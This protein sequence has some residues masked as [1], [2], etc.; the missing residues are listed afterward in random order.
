MTTPNDSR[1]SQLADQWEK[2]GKTLSPSG[3]YERTL[4]AC[5]AELRFVIAGNPPASTPDKI[6]LAMEAD[7]P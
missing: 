3:E 6:R 1:L 5:A 4:R 7:L 2:D